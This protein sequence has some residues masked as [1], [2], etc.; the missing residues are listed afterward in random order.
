MATVTATRAGATKTARDGVGTHTVLSSYSITAN[1][2]AN[3]VLQMVP[4]P[5]GARIVDVVLTSTD[6]DTHGT[7]TVTMIVGDTDSTDDTDRY[8]T[9]ST[10]GQTGG[11]ARL[12]N[13][14]GHLYEF[15]ADGT[16]DITFPAV[17]ATFASGTITLAVTYLTDDAA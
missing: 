16:I 2:T 10:I 12:N 5:K 3:D 8:I 7:P 15:T 1:V 6:I 11:V 4:V 13:Q 17:A 9:S 14:V